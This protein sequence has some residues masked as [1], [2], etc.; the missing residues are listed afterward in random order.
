MSE[1]F[2]VTLDKDIVLDDSLISPKTGWSSKKIQEQIIDKRITRF[3]QLEDV[4][5]VNKKDKQL[6]AFSKDTGKFITIDGA[7]AGEIIGGGMKQVS[8]MGIVGSPTVPYIVEIQINTLDFKVPRVNVLKYEL[9]TQNIIVTK[10]TFSN[11]ESNNFTQD[12][13]ITFDGKVHLK[14]EYAQD[15]AVNRYDST[16]VEYTTILDL[17]KF[18]S[19]EGFEDFEEGLTQ[20]IKLKTVPFDRLLVP[21]SDMNLSNAE[22]IDY[23]KLTATG[24]N[25]RVICSVDSAITWKVFKTDKWINVNLTINDIRAEGMTIENFNKINDTFWNELITSKKIRFAYLFSMDNA[26]DI[27]EL[28]NLD[29]QFDGVGRWIQAKETDFN[30]IYASNTLLQVEVKFSSDIKINY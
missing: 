6:V 17:S 14:T 5:V 2:N 16:F 23:F 24:K 8:K 3:E 12:E 22:H 27:E 11:G 18:K 20:K 10:N 30:V 1:F 15:Y 19:L 28:D 13:F 4:D 26:L 9:G 7:G 21:Q 25:L 29:L